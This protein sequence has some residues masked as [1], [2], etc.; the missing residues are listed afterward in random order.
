MVLQ[1][2][3]LAPDFT[4]PD[5]DSNN[6]T[7]SD[8]KGSWVLLYFYPKDN[9]PGCTKQACSIRDSYSEFKKAGITV[10]GISKDS[11][12]SHKKFE[13]NQNLPFILLADTEKIAIQSYDVW[14]QKKFM[15]REYMGVERS[16]YLINPEGKI[17]AVFENVKPEMHTD[18][19]LNTYN[20]LTKS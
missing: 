11:I 4:L 7:L 14:K 8:L 17:V 3:T 6:H 12:K 15:G 18:L 1:I 5:Q 19:I 16:S 9:T 20:N 10:F 2:N 13:E